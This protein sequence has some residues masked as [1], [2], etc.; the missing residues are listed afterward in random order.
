MYVEILEFFFSMKLPHFLDIV[1]FSLHSLFLWL[2]IRN[3]LSFLYTFIHWCNRVPKKKIQA[4]YFGSIE[5][6]NNEIALWSN[7]A[8]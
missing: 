5:S 6:V 4:L 8:T 2:H 3:F 1:S 7:S